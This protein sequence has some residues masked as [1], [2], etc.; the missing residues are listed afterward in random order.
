M[1][2]GPGRASLGGLAIDPHALTLITHPTFDNSFMFT[3]GGGDLLHNARDTLIP[4]LMMAGGACGREERG[5]GPYGCPS[6]HQP[7]SHAKGARVRSVEFE[8]CARHHG[9]VST[10]A[11][12]PLLSFAAHRVRLRTGQSFVPPARPT[13]QSDFLSRAAYLYVFCV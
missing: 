4:P 8:A 11:S 12:P 5:E 9:R 1:P 7:A 13:R 10:R 2:A 6:I 3:D